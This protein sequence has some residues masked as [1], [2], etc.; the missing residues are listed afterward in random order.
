MKNVLLLVH[1][2]QGQESR[3][4]VAL[5]VTRA[6]GGHLTCLDVIA[7]P[8][9][10]AD[11]LAGP[12]LSILLEDERTRE[13]AIC[14]ALSERLGRE[15]VAWDLRRS[16]DELGLAIRDE[17]QGADLIVLNSRLEGYSVLDAP[18]IAGDALID[19]GRPV[20]AVP[21]GCS[22]IDLK[23]TVLIAWNGSD[24]AGESL[25]AAL[26]L[27]KLAQEVVLFEAGRSNPARP[28]S[29]AAQY[30]SRHGLRCR[31]ESSAVGDSV[32]DAILRAARD[33]G[34]SYIVMGAYGHWRITEAVIGGVTRA[35]L[36]TSDL[37]L[38]LVH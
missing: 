29:E 7:F 28:A 37:P 10:F 13:D 35:M 11:P 3:L 27:L 38:F 30:L 8:R 9:V 16:T 31:T 20:L 18:R 12:A 25:R 24:E 33:V 22:G 6:I 21:D 4:Q 2:D 34:A 17:A 15:D 26:P 36:E 5:D 19:T 23:G 32:A 14:Q 1:D